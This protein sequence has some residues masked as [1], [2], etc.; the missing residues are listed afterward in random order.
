MVIY[1]ILPAAILMGW[2]TWR[3]YE[4]AL[5]LFAFL[6]PSYLVR[7]SVLGVPTNALEV[8]TLAILVVTVLKAEMRKSWQKAW[9]SF[10]FIWK[11][12]IGLWLVAV[13]VSVFISDQ[14]IVS[15]GILKGWIVVPLMAGWMIYVKA[16]HNSK[17]II[18][19]IRAL[20]LSAVS[21]VLLALG[22]VDGL[23]RLHGIYDVPN[24]LA[25]W[26]TPM[27]VMSLWL[28]LKGELRW[29]WVMSGVLALG[30]AMT[31]TVGAM[32][33]VIGTLLV[34]SALLAE[35]KGRRRMLISLLAL[36]VFFVMLLLGSGRLDYFINSNEHTSWD[37]RLQ[38]W[39]ISLELLKD[40]P[41]LG[42]GLGQFEPHYQE[43]LH[44]RAAEGDDIIPEFVFRDPHNW[45]LSFWIN[46]GLLG[47]LSFTAII[48][49]VYKKFWLYR[50]KYVADQVAMLGIT[51]MLLYGLVDTLY[52]K[53]DLAVL[54]WIMMA[55][56]IAL[57]KKPV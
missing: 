35:G 50:R 6:I 40:S 17:F 43:V 57:S 42:V 55:A 54:W 2:L 34:G 20:I 45:L 29:G 19:V 26:L 48:A 16:Q 52:W 1:Y 30:L 9:Q 28:T 12:W 32:I 14:L 5:L 46:L 13:L 33:A 51:A 22:T 47:L 38:L 36:I 10:S 56:S 24:S 37:V 21:M 7:F 27:L 11:F 25:W 4:R 31:Q 53:N 3:W 41:L 23:N 44:Q 49:N 8:L 39:S 18:R 15:L